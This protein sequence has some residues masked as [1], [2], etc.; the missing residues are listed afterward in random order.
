MKFLEKPFNLDTAR[1]TQ[2][3]LC[4]NPLCVITNCRLVIH[5]GRLRA[6]TCS[7]SGAAG[8]PVRRAIPTW[9]DAPSQRVAGAMGPA[10]GEQAGA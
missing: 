7:T 4:L 6:E 8:R 2:R 9:I 3:S 5:L 10:R 1:I